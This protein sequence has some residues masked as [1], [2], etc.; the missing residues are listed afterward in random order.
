MATENKRGCNSAAC[1]RGETITSRVYSAKD[2]SP[3]H[4]YENQPPHNYATVTYSDTCPCTIES[5][6]DL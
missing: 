3:E 4:N 6:I 2:F 1:V 5:W